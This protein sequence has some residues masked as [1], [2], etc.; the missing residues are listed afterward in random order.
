MPLAHESVRRYEFVFL[1][2]SILKFLFFPLLGLL[3]LVCFHQKVLMEI[4]KIMSH[5]KLLFS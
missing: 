1:I 5:L 4:L 2:V 3:I